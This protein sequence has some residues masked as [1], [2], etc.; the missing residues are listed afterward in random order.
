M[1][2]RILTRESWGANE[3]MGIK[4]N[5]E[6]SVEERAENHNHSNSSSVSEKEKKCL[7]MR[8]IAPEDFEVRMINTQDKLGNDLIWPRRYS[9][10]VKVIVVHHTGEKETPKSNSLSGIEKVRAIYKGHTQTNGWGD[11]GYHYLVDKDGK[12]YEGRAGGDNVVGAHVYCANVGTISVAMIGNFQRRYP[13]EKQL[14]SLRWL[15][16]ELTNKYRIRP[17]GKTVFRG[18]R[19]STIV[20]HRDLAAT[21]CAGRNVQRLMNSIRT[22]VAQRDYEKSILPKDKASSRISRRGT[23]KKT[24]ERE[25]PRRV[26]DKVQNY[27]KKYGKPKR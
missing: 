2:P 6:N 18:E 23:G 16:I 10:K 11:I 9:K 3:S 25:I 12:I 8:R 26:R 4:I 19:I 14:S 17:S 13:S 24:Y 15:L 1:S 5:S 27:L 20:T 22:T 7:E 21:Q